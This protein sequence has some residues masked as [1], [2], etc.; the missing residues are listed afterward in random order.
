MTE[1]MAQT[2]P[3]PAS[4]QEGLVHEVVEWRAK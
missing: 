4:S 2:V 3:V 1:V